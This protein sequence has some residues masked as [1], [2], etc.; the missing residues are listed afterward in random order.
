MKR[1]RWRTGLAAATA[2][3]FL[4]VPATAQAANGDLLHRG[5]DADT[6]TWHVTYKGAKAVT[7]TA[8]GSA[9]ASYYVASY[10]EGDLCSILGSP[11]ASGTQRFRMNGVKQ[12]RRWSQFS[13]EDN[14]TSCETNAGIVNGYFKKSVRLTA[15]YTKK[16]GGKTFVATPAVIV[17]L[18]GGYSYGS[19]YDENIVQIRK[20]GSWKFTEVKK[21]K[22]KDGGGGSGGTGGGG[23]TGGTLP[24][25][26]GSPPSTG[27]GI[28]YAGM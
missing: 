12:E 1:F 20:A 23:G 3:G 2:G 18:T 11:K 7:L 10:L 25:P 17:Q 14:A 8:K 13:S 27:G 26:G 9:S 4:V 22:K 5:A 24:P 21:K 15:R 19:Q 28:T 6:K 16:A